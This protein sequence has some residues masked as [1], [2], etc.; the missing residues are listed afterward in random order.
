MADKFKRKLG[1]LVDYLQPKQANHNDENVRVPMKRGRKTNVEEKPK[2]TQVAHRMKLRPKPVQQQQEKQRFAFRHR[3]GAENM[4]NINFPSLVNEQEELDMIEGSD[5]DDKKD[6]VEVLKLIFADRD[7][8]EITHLSPG[9]RLQA[10]ANFVIDN[11][12]QFP[13]QN[14]TNVKQILPEDELEPTFSSLDDAMARDIYFRGKLLDAFFEDFREHFERYFSRPKNSKIEY[15]REIC[16]RLLHQHFPYCRTPLIEHLTDEFSGRFAMAAWICF[17]VESKLGFMVR[18]YFMHIEQAKWTLLSN[19]LPLPRKRRANWIPNPDSGPLAESLH[20]FMSAIR[21][22]RAD[23]DQ[24]FE[25]DTDRLLPNASEVGKVEEF[26]CIVCTGN[27]LITRAVCCNSNQIGAPGNQEIINLAVASTSKT[28]NS[29]SKEM[30]RFCIECLIGH[31]RAATQEMP[32]AKGGIGL[33]CMAPDCPNPILF[34]ECRFYIPPNVRRQLN[35][36]IIEENLGA[37]NL[38]NLERCNQC[39]FAIIIEAGPDQFRVFSCLKCNAQYCRQCKR[40]WNDLHMGRPCTDILSEKE[41]QQRLF[42]NRMSEAIIRRC[43]RCS[44]PFVKL[45]GCNLM[46]CRC[47]ATQCFICRASKVTYAHFC[48]HFRDPTKRNSCGQCKK[49]CLL[50]ESGAEVDARAL[51]TIRLEASEAGVSVDMMV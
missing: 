20:D 21:R 6:P 5:D 45:D 40:P 38:P 17:F 7:V 43:Q 18:K 32:L 25:A 9:A 36:R 49:T 33:R 15:D 47:S 34:S 8:K 48:Q 39:N 42:Q 29:C 1:H 30:H 23:Y 19:P 51:E 41:E 11:A 50:W 3:R 2:L 26:E 16:N 10:M 4:F 31:A 46:R 44:L 27:F 24:I 28:V 37:A 14:N 13:K 12:E 22:F 35:A